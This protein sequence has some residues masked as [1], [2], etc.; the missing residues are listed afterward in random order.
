MTKCI[1]TYDAP[2]R[3]C[4]PRTDYD[5]SSLVLLLLLHSE[6]H[7]FV[8]S[9]ACMMFCEVLTNLADMGTW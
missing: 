1:Q 3:W 4:L 8:A 7:P 6:F 9:S 2:C 5:P